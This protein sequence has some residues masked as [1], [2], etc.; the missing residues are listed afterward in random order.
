MTILMAELKQKLD[1][2][3]LHWFWKLTTKWWFFPVFYVLFVV[4]LTIILW[5]QKGGHSDEAFSFFL[6][7]LYFMPNGLLYLLSYLSKPL[8]TK[9]G[10]LFFIFPGI[11]F[12]IS[13]ALIILPNY[14][15]KQKSLRK[16]IIT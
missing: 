13:T 11:V 5:N 12:I 8:Y 14:Y 4:L 9:T 6:Y 3:Q 7:A 1:D 10:A 16:W 2:S 15:K